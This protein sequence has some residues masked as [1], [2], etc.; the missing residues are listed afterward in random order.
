MLGLPGETDR[1]R[2]QTR[3]FLARVRPPVLSVK[4]YRPYAGVRLETEGQ[5]ALLN[6]HWGAHP[7]SRQELYELQRDWQSLQGEPSK[8]PGWLERMRRMVGRE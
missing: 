3:E 2:T 6:A 8:A 4:I 5:N 7:L 1:A